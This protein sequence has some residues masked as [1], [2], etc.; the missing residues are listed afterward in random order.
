MF[1]FKIEVMFICI[2]TQADLLDNDFG[3]FGLDF[4]C[5]LFLFI[6]E[7]FI[8]NYFT[9]RRAGIGLDLNQVKFQAVGD[10]KRFF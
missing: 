2:R 10:V 7:F 5:F 1:Q 6:K 3:C 8:I 9:N 4:L